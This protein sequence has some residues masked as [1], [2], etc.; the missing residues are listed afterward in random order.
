MASL[1]E[2]RYEISLKTIL[3]AVGVLALLWIVIQLKSLFIALFI[4]LILCL[5]LEPLIAK[6]SSRRIPRTLGVVSVFLALVGIFGGVL[7]YSFTSLVA[8]LGVFLFRLPLLLE[9]VMERIWPL[10]L[11]DQVR[12]ELFSQLTGLSTGLLN[13]TL[14]SAAAIYSNSIFI[15]SILFFAFYLLLDWPNILDRFIKLFNRPMR[16][17]VEVVINR[18]EVQ[19]GGWVRAKLIS[20]AIVGMLSFAGLFILGVEYALPLALIAA[21]LEI[22]PLLGP[23]IAAVPALAVGFASSPWLGL[24]ILALYVVIQQLESNVIIPQVMRKATGF[25]P[26]VTLILLFVGGELF[27]AVGVILALPTALLFAIVAREVFAQ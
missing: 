7:T 24:G 27:G 19:L 10:P 14:N 1:S 12:E 18:V 9:S 8:Q 20:M 2:Q 6:L 3:S 4:A 22:V 16:G 15:L 5:T 23:I 13:T 11:T 25:S 17:R 21:V 26:L